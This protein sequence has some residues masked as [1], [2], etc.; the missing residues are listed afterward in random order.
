MY[1]C[2]LTRIDSVIY[3]FKY[4]EYALNVN[5]GRFLLSIFLPRIMPLFSKL[6]FYR[7]DIILNKIQLNK[8][9]YMAMF[10]IK[11]LLCTLVDSLNRIY[12]KT[13]E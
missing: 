2:T 7:D 5:N 11:F 10:Q 1:S 13:S 6:S 12:K 4:E 8:F 9:V 3:A